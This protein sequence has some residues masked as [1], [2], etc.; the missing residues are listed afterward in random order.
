MSSG[1]FMLQKI[2]ITMLTVVTSVTLGLVA[3]LAV[4]PSVSAAGSSF[5][6]AACN[7]VAQVGGNGCSTGQSTVSNLMTIAINIISLAAGFIAVV[8]IIVSGI[9]FMTAQGDSSGVASARQS[10]IYA[11]I[12]IVVAAIGQIL[13]QFVIGKTTKGL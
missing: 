12:G 7:G 6:Q 11:L 5:Q 10:L 8:M 2:K 13:V 1:L 3:L 9:K 4:A